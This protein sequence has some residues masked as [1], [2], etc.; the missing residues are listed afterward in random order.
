MCLY[1]NI[2]LYIQIRFGNLEYNDN[3][4]DILLVTFMF[5]IFSANSILLRESKILLPN[6]LQLKLIILFI[7]SL[8]FFSV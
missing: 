2:L 1:H 6:A 7:S 4:P 3:L 8:N 5:R